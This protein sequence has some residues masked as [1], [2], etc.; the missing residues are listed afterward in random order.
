MPGAS[1]IIVGSL[2]MGFQWLVMGGARSHPIAI[3]P[4]RLR[5]GEKVADH[6]RLSV[7]ILIELGA[8]ERRPENT[9]AA[10]GI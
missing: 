5:F 6:D 2:S 9:Q 7:G 10:I 8:L 3:S 4:S 1:M